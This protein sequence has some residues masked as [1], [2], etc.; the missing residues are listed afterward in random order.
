MRHITDIPIMSLAL[1]A[2]EKH[3]EDTHMVIEVIPKSEPDENV[4]IDSLT[5]DD[6]LWWVEFEE[7]VKVFDNFDMVSH[8]L[9]NEV[10]KKNDN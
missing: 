4:G 5:E 7:E 6:V 8:Y 10:E 3:G 1:Q 9:L 2:E